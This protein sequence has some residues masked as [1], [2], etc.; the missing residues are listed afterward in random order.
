MKNS[1]F[2]LFLLF[3]FW[4]MLFLGIR[5]ANTNTVGIDTDPD[6]KSYTDIWTCTEYITY[7][8]CIIQ[9][10]ENQQVT[11]VLQKN[12]DSTK[13]VWA[14]LWSDAQ[15]LEKICKNALFA[16]WSQKYLQDYDCESAVADTQAKS[17]IDTT[18]GNWNNWI[19]WAEDDALAASWSVATWEVVDSIDIVVAPQP[20]ITKKVQVVQNR[21]WFLRIRWW[22]WLWFEE[23]GRLD[24]WDIAN[25]VSEQSWWYQIQFGDNNTLWWVS[26]KYVNEVLE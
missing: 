19:E 24:I 9:K 7:M 12:L 15:N 13:R 14:G 11:D 6:I 10:I 4:F 20:V 22:A 1:L 23:V 2:T 5:T 21:L 25:A 17:I 26:G 8:E 16:L 3:L 18:I